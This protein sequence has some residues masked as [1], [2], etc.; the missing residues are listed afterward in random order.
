MTR[1]H[2]SRNK[3]HPQSSSRSRAPL[4]GAAVI[5]LTV[6]AIVIA[7]AA[8]HSTRLDDLAY[9]PWL[10]TGVQVLAL[11]SAGTRR[12]WGWLLG[13]AVQPPWIA[14]AVVSAQLGFIPG[15]AVSA[16]V[17]AHS[18]LAGGTLATPRRSNGSGEELCA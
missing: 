10:L 15:C 11:W 6:S 17:Q 8:S 1:H 16:A 5:S 18:F 9:W 12:W 4:L 13:A 7:T 14:Y 2:L 3:S